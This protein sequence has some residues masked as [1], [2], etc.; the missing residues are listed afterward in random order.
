[1]KKEKIYSFIY[2]LVLASILV[3]TTLSGQFAYVGSSNAHPEYV[4]AIS[5]DGEDIKINTKAI[6]TISTHLKSELDIL[7][8]RVDLNLVGEVIVAVSIEKDGNIESVEILGEGHVQFEK[9]VRDII[10]KIDK[11]EPITYDGVA[12]DKVVWIPLQLNEK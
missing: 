10:S 8:N 3:S 4:D 5:T 2:G 9:L 7:K 1:M 11:V 6:K 12:K